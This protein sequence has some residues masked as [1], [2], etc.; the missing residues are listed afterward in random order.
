[1]ENQLTI[2]QFLNY[3]HDFEKANLI[4]SYWG[5]YMDRG[6]FRWEKYRNQIKQI[7]TSGHIDE[8]NLKELVNMLE[9]KKI[10]PI[11]TLASNRFKELFGD[12]ILFL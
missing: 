6:N 2:S 7:H 11:H 12:K 8:N 4:Y 5:G 1:M 10:I 9:P 3:H